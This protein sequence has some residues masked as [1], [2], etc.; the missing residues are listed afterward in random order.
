M[1]LTLAFWI[2]M[3]IWLFLGAYVNRANL[4]AWGGN[5]L[6]LFLILLLLGDR[7]SVV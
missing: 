3:L 6:L 2:C 4:P 7:K 1:T 5:S